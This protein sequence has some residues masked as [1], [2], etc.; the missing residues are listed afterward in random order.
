[1]I[2]L[3]VCVKVQRSMLVWLERD[4]APKTRYTRNWPQKASLEICATWDLCYLK[5]L[6]ESTWKDLANFSVKIKLVAKME[7]FPRSWM[8][9]HSLS[10]D[11]C[12]RNMESN[13]AMLTHKAL[14]RSLIWSLTMKSSLLILLASWMT[15]LLFNEA[16]DLE[17]VMSWL[18][19][20][21]QY[22][23]KYNAS[24]ILW[25]WKTWLAVSDELFQ[26][27]SFL[28]LLS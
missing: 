6:Y 13:C 2:R 10:Y 1:M 16:I 25:K 26:W 17:R 28:K 24:D 5:S 21:H 12:P 7:I 27:K 8:Q 9:M 15:A 20:R 18:R 22:Q 23:T 14:R 19:L 4:K 3:N 11:H